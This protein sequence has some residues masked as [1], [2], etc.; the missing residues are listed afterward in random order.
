MK[1]LLK[2]TLCGALL[3]AGP[4]IAADDIILN[5]RDGRIVLVGDSFGRGLTRKGTELSYARFVTIDND[6]QVIGR[7]QFAVSGCTA[8]AAARNGRRI[9]TQENTDDKLE[10]KEWSESGR[11]SHDR[12]A[13][14]VCAGAAD[15]RMSYIEP[16][17]QAPQR[18][19]QQPVRKPGDLT[20]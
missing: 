7:G 17:Q 9:A 13:R 11:A 18:A 3:I 16:P 6:G 2:T 5:F 4:A 20:T 12:I 1:T 8:G 19:P 10:L 14:A 15:A